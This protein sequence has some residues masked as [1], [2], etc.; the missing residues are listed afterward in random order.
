MKI[1]NSDIDIETLVTEINPLGMIR[2]C[3]S[4]NIYLSD[5]DVEILKKYNFDINNYSTIE[6]LIFDIEEYLDTNYDL[7]LD[8]LER[9]SIN[10][11]EFNYYQNT[12]K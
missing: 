9:L 3:Y 5:S 7:E 1:N 10:L 6:S 8:D 11:S 4:N 12:N 2:K